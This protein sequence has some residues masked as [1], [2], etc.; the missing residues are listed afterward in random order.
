[1]ILDKL[2]Q[3]LQR[4]ADGFTKSDKRIASIEDNLRSLNGILG[5]TNG[6]V[7]VRGSIKTSTEELRVAM[8]DK[9]QFDLECVQ[10]DVQ[11]SSALYVAISP[12]NRKQIQKLLEDKQVTYLKSVLENHKK[13]NDMATWA[14][15]FMDKSQG[16]VQ[17]R[18]VEIQNN[19][20]KSLC[21]GEDSV[22][23]K[24]DISADK[25]KLQNEKID[26]AL[27]ALDSKMKDIDKVQIEARKI[28]ADK[29]K[30]KNKI[31]RPGT[32]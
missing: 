19:V 31:F 14:Q 1:V 3:V 18:I 13:L 20:K 5:S 4:L 26:K 21:E 25:L 2:V 8:Q 27:A 16:N 32:K 10:L 12:R 22:I 15:D 9:G 28:V 7:D 29:V 11:F 30:P 17:A 6:V 24:L 23:K